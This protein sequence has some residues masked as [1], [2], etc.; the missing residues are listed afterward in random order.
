MNIKKLRE[1]SGKTP[2]E[3]AKV[4]NIS[5]QSYYRYES[6]QNEPNIKNL[7]ILAD[8]YNVSTDYLCEHT[9]NN[10]NELGYIDSQTMQIIQV[11]QNLNN[12]NKIKAY[13]YISGLLAGQ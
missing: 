7:K 4:L 12:T 5:L 11:L 13:A 6:G 8:M 3:L 9:V 2:T 10:K 1:N